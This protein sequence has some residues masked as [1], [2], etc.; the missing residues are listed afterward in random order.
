[1]KEIAQDLSFKKNKIEPPDFY[2]GARLEKK[3][4]NGKQMWTMTSKDYVKAA[5]DNVEQ[6]LAKRNMKLPARAPTPMSMD[7]SPETDDTPELES[8]QVTTYQEC[9]G[10]LRWAIEIG[11]VDI[12]TEVSMLSAYQASPRE[13]HLEQIYHIF[14]YLKKKPKLTLYFE[15]S[16]PNLDPS[17]ASGDSPSI[18]RETYRDAKEEI[19]PDHLMPKPRG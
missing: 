10:I 5:I 3:S 16:I 17:W 12:M 14:A 11:R 8:D 13:G 7:Y 4:L 18:F 15:P 9:I 2:L 19:P 1:M 6:Q